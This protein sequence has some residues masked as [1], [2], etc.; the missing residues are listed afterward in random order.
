MEKPPAVVIIARH[1]ARLDAVDKQWHLTSATPYDPP[2]TYGGWNQ[3]RAL[4]ARIISLLRAREASNP[5]TPSHDVGKK[6]AGREALLVPTNRPPRK[7]KV[8]IHTSPYLRCLQTAIA[9]SAGISQHYGAPETAPQMLRSSSLPVNASVAGA[10]PVT[11]GIP[12]DGPLD[13]GGSSPLSPDNLSPVT[14]PG[15]ARPTPSG[16]RCLLRVDAFLGEWL[17]PDYFDQITP[18]PNSERMVAA[19]KEELLRHEGE[20]ARPT[21]GPDRPLPGYFPGGWGSRASPMPTVFDE[22]ALEVE[23]ISSSTAATTTTTSLGS[24]GQRT[25]AGSHDTHLSPVN[26]PRAK[27]FLSKINTELNVITDG[28]Y[29]PPTPTY[30]VSSSHPIPAGYVTHARE[31]CVDIDY[32]WDS[33]R[34]PQN[35]GD[36]GQHGEEWSTMH[37]RL[38]SGLQNMIDWYSRTDD[39]KSSQDEEDDSTDTVL[40]IITHGAGCNALI[41]ALTGH[42]VLL[43]I[44]MASLTMAVRRDS[45]E[46]SGSDTL[47]DHHHR[48]HPH[49]E[50]H[51]HLNNHNNHNHHHHHHLNNN[52]NNNNNDHQQHRPLRHQRKGS[53]H[54]SISHDYDLKLVASSDHLRAGGNPAQL[55]SMAASQSSGSYSSSPISSYRHRLAAR[56]TLSQDH[57]MIGPSIPHAPSGRS[58]SLAMRPSTAPRGASGLWGSISASSET[59]IDPADDIVPNFGDRPKSSGNLAEP[60]HGVDPVD[61]DPVDDSSWGQQLP[62]RTLSQRGLW[63]SAPTLQERD[64]SMKRRWTVTERRPL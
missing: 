57:F 28:A 19:A 27:G 13:V 11:Q 37:M 31:S 49:Q 23:P 39:A 62:H 54:L 56:S 30:A 10:P 7:H 61:S 52:N 51:V 42:P 29:V 22:E 53:I 44:G 12:E 46:P 2:L 15:G 63:G 21:E 64:G 60:D 59:V 47:S 14:A 24:K 33:M 41:G 50:H 18:P 36:G 3:S 4:G 6:D 34:E 58:W 26:N 55:P 48:Q 32:R 25:R 40:I 1:G 38:R 35:W 20:M 9:V 8:I 45:S 16:H 43:D 17:S 5:N